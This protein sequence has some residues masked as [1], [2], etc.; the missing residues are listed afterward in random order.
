MC[1][2]TD[3]LT[4]KSAGDEISSTGEGRHLQFVESA[5]THPTHADGFVDGGDPVVIG[6]V[7]GV[8]FS[9][10]AAATD[11]I[12]IDTEGIWALTCSATDAAGN[13]AIAAGNEIYIN[14]TTCALSKI[15]TPGTHQFFGNALTG[16]A[17]GTSGLVAV[18]VHNDPQTIAQALDYFVVSKSGNDSN[19]GSWCAPLLTIQAALDAVT[20]TRKVVYVLDGTY[21]EALTWPTISGVKLIGLN[22]EWG[23]VVEDATETA[24]VITVTP[25]VQTST[26]EMW[27]ENIY[28]NHS[29]AG[30]DGLALDNT[31]MTKKLNCYIRDC[32]GEANSAADRFI[33][34]TQGDNNNAI[35]IYWNGQNG[36]VE[37]SIYID[38]GND[39]I[40]FYATNVTF[41]GGLATAADAIALDMR[42]LRCFVLHEGITGGNAAQTVHAICC[43]SVTGATYAAL[44]TLDLAGSHTQDIV[45]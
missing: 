13:S 24:A 30:Q 21:D 36:D 14:K 28:I 26:F 8:A 33:V 17:T 44:D 32:G 4:G 42:L 9:G 15:N 2:Y 6:N 3:L 40:R 38:A 7:V 12:A 11:E 23:V 29:N 1:V 39:G 41:A 18:K 20:A 22:R 19:V 16:L 10:A 27:L 34:T 25:G 37:G 31:A 35:R 5:I 43:Y 45:A